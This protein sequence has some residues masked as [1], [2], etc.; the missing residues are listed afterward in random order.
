MEER[1]KKKTTI[2]PKIADYFCLVQAHHDFNL[3]CVLICV[4]NTGRQSSVLDF[5]S[6][7]KYKIKV[8]KL[9]QSIGSS[10]SLTLIYIYNNKS[11]AQEKLHEFA[12]ESKMLC[13]LTIGV[14]NLHVCLQEWSH[15]P[16]ILKIHV[17]VR[18]I[19]TEKHKK[20][21]SMHFLYD[22]VA[23]ML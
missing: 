22:W 9:T 4:L 5:L 12:L 18:W 8:F 21:P 20:R 19:Y 6:R 7:F 13:W 11:G 16:M 14:P 3:L 2:C 23:A 17:R 10:T 15:I 1:R